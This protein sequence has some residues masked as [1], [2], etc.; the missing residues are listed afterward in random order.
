MPRISAHTTVL[1]HSTGSKTHAG[2]CQGVWCHAYPASQEE[3]KHFVQYIS[4]GRKGFGTDQGAGQSAPSQA[5]G[6][7]Q[8]KRVKTTKKGVDEVFRKIES[9]NLRWRFDLGRNSDKLYATFNPSYPFTDLGSRSKSL[10]MAIRIAMRLQW[11]WQKKECP[12]SQ[13]VI[14]YLC[15]QPIQKISKLEQSVF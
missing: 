7:S 6:A 1:V 2:N 9:V 14:F 11:L 13:K 10:K 12:S 8:K 15:N 5:A 3:D 4:L